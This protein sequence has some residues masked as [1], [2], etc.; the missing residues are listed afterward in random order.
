MNESIQCPPFLSLRRLRR[1][2]RL[3]LLGQP[4]VAVVVVSRLRYST[5]KTFPAL[6][7]VE[8]SLNF[9]VGS[10]CVH[11]SDAIIVITELAQIKNS[12]HEYR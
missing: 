11:N 4:V 12:M 9:V 6:K 2:R 10:L 8:T 1:L 7:H 3:L 5:S